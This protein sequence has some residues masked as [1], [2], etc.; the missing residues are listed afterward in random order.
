MAK[1]ASKI[2]IA[3]RLFWVLGLF[4]LITAVLGIAVYMS[5]V[6]MPAIAAS[7][8]PVAVTL[9]LSVIPQA[10]T[11][12]LVGIIAAMPLIFTS[13]LMLKWI[14]LHIKNFCCDYYGNL[15]SL[16]Q[17]WSTGKNWLLNPRGQWNDL[18]DLELK[19]F[20]K[21]FP[22]AVYLLTLTMAL[23]VQQ[24]HPSIAK[25]WRWQLLS[26]VIIFTGGLF[27]SIVLFFPSLFFIKTAM[28]G[29][30]IASGA[31]FLFAFFASL[32]AYFMTS[33]L[34]SLPLGLNNLRLDFKKGKFKL[35]EKM[36]YILGLILLAI[37]T[38]LLTSVF[39]LPL[40]TLLTP[41]LG[42]G[43][44]CFQAIVV[45]FALFKLMLKMA[46]FFI[47]G[48]I[49]IKEA[50]KRKKKTSVLKAGVTERKRPDPP[51]ILDRD[52]YVLYGQAVNKNG[53]CPHRYDLM[54]DDIKEKLKQPK[55]KNNKKLVKKLLRIKAEFLCLEATTTAKKEGKY[56]EAKEIFD[57]L[58]K[59]ESIDPNLRALAEFQ[60]RVADLC[61][62]YKAVNISYIPEQ[63]SE[64]N[65]KLMQLLLA[66]LKNP[67]FEF[68]LGIDGTKR[69]GQGLLFCVK[70][71]Y[72]LN[73]DAVWDVY[74][75]LCNFIQRGLKKMAAG[76]IENYLRELNLRKQKDCDHASSA[77]FAPST[78]RSLSRHSSSA[79]EKEQ[80]DNLSLSVQNA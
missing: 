29:L 78:P 59:D 35:K 57:N 5:I 32:T 3:W 65:Y 60:Y 44:A 53:E 54:I 8:S 10:L 30:G 46:D 18:G 45:S 12:G 20:E 41:A 21:D 50:L 39:F 31:A 24:L 56:L 58:R 70:L 28:L 27:D 37:I 76:K 33:Q 67:S 68:N 23:P 16:S 77:E 7:L 25:D 14:V 42:S 71:F 19:D 11:L 43:L 66:E 73:G 64:F 38:A 6:F 79:E 69:E 52:L 80:Q 9:G 55:I 74:T 13:F 26:G 75:D 34:V 2:T 15:F 61:L 4:S 47:E 36:P 51:A 48:I 49:W 17:M 22:V 1:T 62:R 63:T 72:A 40:I